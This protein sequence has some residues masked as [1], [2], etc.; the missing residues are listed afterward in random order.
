M[1]SLSFGTSNFKD[2]NSAIFYYENMGFSEHDVRE[3]VRRRDRN[4][5]P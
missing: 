1:G 2:L 4:W 3:K 5:I